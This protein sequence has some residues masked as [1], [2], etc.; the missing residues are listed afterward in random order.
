MLT[1]SALAYMTYRGWTALLLTNI[2]NINKLKQLMEKLREQ[3]LYEHSDEL[4]EI[5]SDFELHTLYV[6]SDLFLEDG[7][8][9]TEFLE[10]AS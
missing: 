2:S 10:D 3:K 5:I 9:R 4:R 8:R 7:S 6:K 1:K